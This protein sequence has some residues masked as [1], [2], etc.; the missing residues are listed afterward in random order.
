MS[1]NSVVN[2]TGLALP[3]NTNWK[4]QV[5]IG[6]G[7]VVLIAVV[8]GQAWQFGFVRWDDNEYVYENE[9]V[10]AGLT[11]KGVTWAFTTLYSTGYWHPLTWL[12]HMLDCQLFG[13]HPGWHHVT[14]ITIHAINTLLVLGIV[15]QMTRRQWCAAATAALF[16]IHP[17]HVESVLWL[18]E[19]KDLLCTL[20]ELLAIG[21]YLRY[22]TQ[23]NS[24]VRYLTV[25]GLTVLSALSKPSMVALPFLLFL[26]DFWPLKRI[27]LPQT[28]HWKLFW[29]QG[30][31][32]LWEK[33]PLIVISLMIM[34][35]TYVGTHQGLIAAKFGI[36]RSS[37]ATYVESTET[38]FS[39][40]FADALVTTAIFL[41]RTVWP[42]GLSFFYECD[43]PIAWWH[44]LI[45][46]VVV[47]GFSVGSLWMIRRAP[48]LAVGWWWYLL[49]LFPV[50]G[51]VAIATPR[52]D[53]YSYFSLIGIFLA[54][55]L[56]LADVVKQ[57]PG[58]R[59]VAATGAGVLLLGLSGLSWNQAQTWKN[60]LTLFQHATLVDP[61][62]K[63]AHH[64][65]AEEY[66]RQEQYELASQHFEAA[67]NEW[68]VALANQKNQAGQIQALRHQL[69]AN[70]QDA[71]TQLALGQTYAQR[72]QPE[73]A[74]PYLQRSTE[75]SPNEIEAWIALG[76]VYLQTGE[77]PKALDAFSRALK[78]DPNRIE[79]RQQVETLRE[80]TGK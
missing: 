39:H 2:E 19:R 27:D 16:A 9:H 53:H 7:L 30:W 58:L 21:T 52:A 69:A 70:P 54:L 10:I 5:W 34:L 29:V 56:G 32:L 67:G 35:V 44:L 80:K 31:Q 13:V 47:F 36:P 38:P 51:I 79:V 66:F 76:K 77:H 6:V 60:S 50:S 3:I 12:S 63:I 71:R 45:A 15:N 65:L 20:F 23:T 26:L 17:I 41:K 61:N 25:I 46:G 48:Y 78:L 11:L 57:K 64:K 75:L 73:D 62:N 24:W 28:G 14:N 4:L 18:S 72:G 40:Q 49:V 42:A 22:G 59:F 74:L 1:T 33:L 55:S 68:G 8:Y 37:T 43:D